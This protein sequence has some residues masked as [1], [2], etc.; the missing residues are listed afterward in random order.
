MI[1]LT[2]LSKRFELGGQ[3]ISALE[4]VSLTIDQ[5]SFHCITGSSGSGKSTLLSLVGGLAPCT[6]GTITSPFGEITSFSRKK[7]ANYRAKHVGIVFQSFNLINH[8]PAWQNV[9][10]GALF[11]SMTRQQRRRRA[12]EMLELVGL[13]DRAA[14][15]PADLSGGEQQRI[16][17]ARAL[18]KEPELLLADEPTGNLDFENANQVLSLLREQ[19][20]SGKTIVLVTH[21]ELI[22]S[23]YSTHRTHLYYGKVSSTESIFTGERQ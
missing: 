9:A 19:Q 8:L 11:D 6:S 20:Q 2:D 3:T 4:N 12:F 21:D 7:L 15:K 16:A 13:S 23:T 18:I 22:A 14:H 10:Y 17:I 1:E 5:G